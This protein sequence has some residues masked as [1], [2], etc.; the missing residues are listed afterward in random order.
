MKDLSRVKEIFADAMLLSGDERSAF[1]DRACGDDPVLR[2]EVE[3]Y[4]AA[5]E[6]TSSLMGSE[7]ITS[8][9]HQPER[10]GTVIGRYKL[11]EQIGEGGFGVV[12]MAE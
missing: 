12:F 9:A 1:L 2:R 8:A 4:L 7:D 11:L 3:A 6:R 10:P 5:S